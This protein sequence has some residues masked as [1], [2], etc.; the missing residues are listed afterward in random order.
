MEDELEVNGIGKV[1]KGRESRV[2]GRSKKQVCRGVWV[3]R[4]DEDST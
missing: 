4:E 1:G 3:G 2:N